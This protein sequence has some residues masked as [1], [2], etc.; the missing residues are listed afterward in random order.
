MTY[1]RLPTGWKRTSAV[2]LGGIKKTV[3]VD[4]YMVPIGQTANTVTKTYTIPEDGYYELFCQVGI[5]SPASGSYS[6]SITWTYQTTET[7]L[8][9]V[10]ESISSTASSVEGSNQRPQ[11][12][13]IAYIKANTVITFT[14][15]AVN[16][17]NSL[18]GY[19][20]TMLDGYKYNGYRVTKIEEQ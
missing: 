13:G 3:L 12:K 20:A 7:S 11:S 17:Q 19:E 18:Y 1:I 15:S 16:S 8:R 10:N 5:V 2:K 6:S 9:I 14:G 4:D